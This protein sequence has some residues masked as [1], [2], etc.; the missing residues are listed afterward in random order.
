MIFLCKTEADFLLW[1]KQI[2]PRALSDLKAFRRGELD[3]H[4]QRERYDNALA[5]KRQLASL[6]Y[7]LDGMHLE[8]LDKCLIENEAFERTA[9]E[10]ELKRE[11]FLVWCNICFPDG[12]LGERM[13]D[14]L[15]LGVR[16]KDLRVQKG[17]G[18]GRVSDLVGVDKKTLYSYE[19]GKCQVK[20]E[21]MYKLSKLYGVRIDDLLSEK[22]VIYVGDSSRYGI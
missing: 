8:F 4:E 20:L 16:L 21:I 12:A 9:V 18:V 2:V 5:V 10:A 22:G 6:R 17:L 13:I 15:V 3:A 1:C 19:S 14:N 7:S 11:V